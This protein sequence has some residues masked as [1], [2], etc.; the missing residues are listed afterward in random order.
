MTF[1]TIDGAVI[2][3]SEALKY[4][5]NIPFVLSLNR[6]DSKDGFSYA[7][8]LNQ[9]FSINKDDKN[10]NSEE[11]YLQ[12]NLGIGL[13]KYSSFLLA[14]FA[15]KLHQSLPKSETVKSEEILKSLN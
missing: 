3:K 4:C 7:I 10:K 2:P 6:K 11:A 14:N 5:N 13:P 9:S 8:N 1:Y 15:N 12:Y